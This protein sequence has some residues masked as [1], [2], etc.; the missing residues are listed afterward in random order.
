MWP[1]ARQ[2]RIHR[3]ATDRQTERRASNKAGHSSFGRFQQTTSAMT[4]T[5]CQIPYSRSDSPSG[6]GPRIAAILARTG[7]RGRGSL[8]CTR[9]P[10]VE[11]RTNRAG[12]LPAVSYRIHFHLGGLGMSRRLSPSPLLARRRSWRR[13]A[14][15]APSPESVSPGSADAWATRTPGHLARYAMMGVPQE[16]P[17]SSAT[18]RSSPT[19]FAA[20]LA[21]AKRQAGRS[22]RGIRGP[23]QRGWSTRKPAALDTGRRGLPRQTSLIVDPPDGRM[24]VMTPEGSSAPPRFPPAAITQR[25]RRRVQQ[26]RGPQRLRPVHHTRRRRFHQ[27]VGY[28]AGNEIVQGPGYVALRNE[29]I[30]EVRVFPLDGRP[31]LSS[32]IRTYMGDSRAHW[33][34]DA[35]R[36]HHELQRDDRRRRQRPGDLPQRRPASCRALH[37]RRT[38]DDRLRGCRDGSQNMAAA[39]DDEVSPDAGR[40]QDVRIRLPRGQLRTAEHPQRG[41]RHGTARPI[42]ACPGPL[43]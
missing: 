20:R 35:C 36:R 12:V 30:H 19:K 28:N 15:P 43:L 11:R 9:S 5:Q 10:V 14:P 25:R 22:Q 26:R 21:Q 31:H 41:A 23:A 6:I 37:A 2:P 16:R 24:P 4:N 17:R 32:A 27:P 18:G 8:G 34:G 42:T 33:E 39:L 7:T 1:F 40:L 38:A 13:R 3:G 29:M